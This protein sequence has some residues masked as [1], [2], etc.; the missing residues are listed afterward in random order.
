MADPGEAPTSRLSAGWAPYADA[1]E[2]TMPQANVTT[3]S[4]VRKATSDDIEAL[5]PTLAAAFFDDPVLSWIYPDVGDRSSRLRGFFGPILRAALPCG[6]TDTVPGNHAAAIW[7]PPHAEIDEEPM[8][9]EIVAASG[10]HAD[11]VYTLMEAIDDKHPQDTP[12]HYLF[13]LGTRPEWQSQG[14]GSA[15]LRS[16]LEPSDVDGVPAYL[17]A[18]SER[19][20]QLYLRHGFEVR[21]EVVLPDGPPLW[22]MWRDPNPTPAR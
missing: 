20:R 1:R 3:T 12:H 15:L 6:G 11:R 2:T 10:P 22:C 7:L 8:V 17:E 19:N 4:N 9:E 5:C 18:S 14:L 16:V 13:V 21:Q